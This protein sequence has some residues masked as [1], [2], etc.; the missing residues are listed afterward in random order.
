MVCFHFLAI[1]NSAQWTFVYKVLC[2]HRFSFLGYTPRNRI[3]RS[4]FNSCLTNLELPDCFPKQ[5]NHLAFPPA[6]Y[7]GSNFL[8]PHRHFLLSVFPQTVTLVR[9]QHLTVVLI[10]IALMPSDAGYLFRAYFWWLLLSEKILFLRKSSQGTKVVGLRNT[11]VFVPLFHPGH[12]IKTSLY[13]FLPS[14]LS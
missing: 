7:E 3:V 12:R 8:A 11:T 4:N 10:C 2:S 1:T 13:S 6:M 14:H 5:L 9:K